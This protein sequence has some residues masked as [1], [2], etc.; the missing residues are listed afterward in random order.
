MDNDTLLKQRIFD[1]L[2]GDLPREGPGSLDTAVQVL[3]LA[4]PFPSV[5]TVLDIGCGTGAQTVDLA[6]L[7]PDARITALDCHAPYLRTLE[8]KAA[9]AGFA[10][11]LDIVQGD[12]GDLP[13]EP[14][15]FDLIWCQGAAYAIGFEQALRAWKRLL[16]PN[17][18]LAVAE[19]VWLRND[20]PTSVLDFWSAY[21]TMR[22]VDSLRRIAADCNYL[23][24]GDLI[25]KSQ[26]WWDEYYIP[27]SR[28]IDDLRNLFL[29]NPE[30]QS[31]LDD[32][33]NEIDLYTKYSDFYGYAFFVL[34]SI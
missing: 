1:A 21:P 11:R 3:T 17:G 13:F 4:Q 28:K 6:T 29:D 18:V 7:L 19:P 27:L 24:R 31:I 16:K 34:E 9:A 32:H 25:M 10:E 30:A 23:A 20:A 26:D 22:N 14:A 15:R 2:H 12:M 33:S 8:R 5:A